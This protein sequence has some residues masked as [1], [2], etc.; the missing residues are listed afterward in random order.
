MYKQCIN[1]VG[2]ILQLFEKTSKGIFWRPNI[3]VLG[4]WVV[5]LVDIILHTLYDIIT[6]HP[7]GIKKLT[8]NVRIIIPDKPTPIGVVDFVNVSLEEAR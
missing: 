4:I 2:G 6:I 5:R 8:N 7:L 3:R 1:K